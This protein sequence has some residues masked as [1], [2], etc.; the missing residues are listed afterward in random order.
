MMI[1]QGTPCSVSA[2]SSGT[3]SGYRVGSP[4]VRITPDERCIRAAAR[5]AASSRV[6]SRPEGGL[7]QNWQCWLHCLVT[8]R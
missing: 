7:E 1:R 2:V 4:P 5:L 3:R 8:W 6:I